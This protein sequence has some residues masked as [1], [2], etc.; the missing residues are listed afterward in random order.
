MTDEDRTAERLKGFNVLIKFKDREEIFLG[1][2]FND[3]EDEIEWF[4]Q[5]EQFINGKPTDDDFFPVV[6]MAVARDSIKYVKKI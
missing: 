2:G 5:V 6:G 3:D 1:I 4:Q